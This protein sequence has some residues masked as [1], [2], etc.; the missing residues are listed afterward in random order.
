MSE[1]ENITYFYK[2]GMGRGLKIMSSKYQGKLKKVST[3]DFTIVTVVKPI[4]DAS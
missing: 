4:S 2:P 3:R 1:F